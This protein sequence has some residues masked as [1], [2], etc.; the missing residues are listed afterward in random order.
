MQGLSYQVVVDQLVNE[1]AARRA[2]R[3]RRPAYLAL[4]S[5]IVHGEARAPSVDFE[6]EF[7]ALPQGS[8]AA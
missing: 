5:A 2:M 7:T 6:R 1:L 3:L 4:A 8:R